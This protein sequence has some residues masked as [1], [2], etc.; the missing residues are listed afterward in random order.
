MPYKTILHLEFLLK[1]Y[2]KNFELIPML[3]FGN[4]SIK[5]GGKA[6]NKTGIILFNLNSFENDLNSVRIGFKLKEH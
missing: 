1:N 4:F 6:A 3:I 2:H 5:G